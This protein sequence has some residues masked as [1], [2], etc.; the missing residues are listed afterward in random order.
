[1]A[2]FSTSRAIS[3][4]PNW[5]F[6]KFHF[7]FGVGRQWWGHGKPRGSSHMALKVWNM[8]PYPS[9]WGLDLQVY[10]NANCAHH[11]SPEPW[12][13]LCL[14]PGPWT[15][16]PSPSHR[17][18]FESFSET[19]VLPKAPQNPPCWLKQRQQQKLFFLTLYFVV[20]VLWH[21]IH[22]WSILSFHVCESQ[23][24][25]LGCEV[26]WQTPVPTEPSWWSRH[27]IY[28]LEKP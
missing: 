9:I 5:C 1:M 12:T 13:V 14:N 17:Q 2:N 21:G 28:F 18:L 22:V 24:L 16:Q 15:A 8:E 25:N 11:W 7:F 10:C 19:L 3:L 4:A 27:K 20:E 26:L 6:K 23:G